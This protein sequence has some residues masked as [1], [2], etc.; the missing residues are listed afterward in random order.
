[1]R[2]KILEE[3]KKIEKLVTVPVQE[4]P[5]KVL[6]DDILNGKIIKEEK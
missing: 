5:V 4:M 6:I 2:V 1:M 3:L